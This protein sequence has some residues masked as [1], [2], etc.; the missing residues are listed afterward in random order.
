MKTQTKILLICNALLVF[1]IIWLLMRE[2]Y[3]KRIYDKLTILKTNSPDQ[4]IEYWFNRNKLFEFFPKDSNSIVFL[5]NS[6]TQN[7]ELAELFHK[8]NLKNR[9]IVG[10]ITK[11]VLQRLKPIIESQPKKIFIEIGIN[12]LFMEIPPDTLL[13]NYTLIL[14]ELQLQCLHTKI[15][16]QSLLPVSFNSTTLSKVNASRINNDI[17][18]VNKKLKEYV[19]KKNLG[20]IDLYSE[21]QLNGTLDASLT[22][23]GVHLNG[24]GY[25]LWTKILIP[26]VEE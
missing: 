20:Y 13:K 18:Y 1:L 14:N 23:D 3:P 7:F 21:F 26:Y 9:G 4:K 17:N 6:L 16:A 22:L 5:G 12:D 19:A 25:L 8:A 24:K 2:N 11:G 15:Y 10:D